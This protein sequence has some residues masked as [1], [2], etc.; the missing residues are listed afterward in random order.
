MVFLRLDRVRRLHYIYLCASRPEGLF[1][2]FQVFSPAAR[3]DSCNSEHF[4]LF[5]LYMEHVFDM[6]HSPVPAAAGGPPQIARSSMHMA[7][8]N[9]SLSADLD[10]HPWTVCPD[11]AHIPNDGPSIIPHYNVGGLPTGLHCLSAGNRNIL[12][13]WPY[14]LSS[15]LKS[16]YLPFL[17]RISPISAVRS[18]HGIPFRPLFRNYA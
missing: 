10:L 14:R 9:I 17:D 2:C 1:R 13:A 3:H 15:P 11:H 16:S 4:T 12:V 6:A 8:D 7:C 18:A 5:V